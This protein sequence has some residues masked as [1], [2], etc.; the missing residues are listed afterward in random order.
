MP[1][2]TVHAKDSGAKAKYVVVIDRKDEKAG[3]KR[4]KFK[5]REA[6]IKLAELLHKRKTDV[7]V[8]NPSGKQIFPC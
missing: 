3:V 5:K 7:K 4:I 6:A 2:H 1:K 8:L